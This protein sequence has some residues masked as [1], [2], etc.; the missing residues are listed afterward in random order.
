MKGGVKSL[1]H[2]HGFGLIEMLVVLL[3]SAM[4]VL[5]VA[6]LNVISLQSILR[7]ERIADEMDHQVFGVQGLMANL[8][9]AGLGVDDTVLADVMPQ[10]ILINPS[11]LSRQKTP[12]N[13]SSLLTRVER[14]RN[15]R[16]MRASEQLTIIY[17]ASL[18]MW[19]CEGQIVLGPRRVRLKN[20]EMAQVGGQVVIERYFVGR[21]QD[22]GVGLRCDAGRFVPE[23]I[24]RDGTR[25]KKSRQSSP[26]FLRAII[27]RSA[28]VQSAN[29]LVGFGDQGEEIVSGV[30]GLWVQFGVQKADGVELMSINEYVSMPMDNPAPIVSLNVAFLAHLPASSDEQVRPPLE[31]FGKELQMAEVERQHGKS[32][33][34]FY[35]RLRNVAGGKS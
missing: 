11:Q 22:G 28:E 14:S 31:L 35:V 24:E 20:G 18:D 10:G 7:Q 26:S 17:R 9:L 12:D 3:L 5:M 2:L 25:D 6:R 19:D 16:T 8:R 27:D 34:T 32:V 30:E 1:R 29:Q 15:A 4:I 33:H 21:H 13:I 23:E